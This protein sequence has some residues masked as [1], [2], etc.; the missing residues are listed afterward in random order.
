MTLFFKITDCGH[1]CLGFCGDPCPNVCSV[2]DP[3]NIIPN[4]KYILLPNCSHVLKFK[5]ITAIMNDKFIGL[6]KCPKCETMIN[7]LPRFKESLKLKK[8]QVVQVFDQYFLW[9]SNLSKMKEILINES[10][11]NENFKKYV[12]SRCQDKSSPLGLAE[13]QQLK[14]KMSL[15]RQ[16][17]GKTQYENILQYLQKPKTIIGPGYVQDLIKICPDLSLEEDFYAFSTNSWI[18][19]TDT[20]KVKSIGK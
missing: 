10:C 14:L 9:K 17:H 4:E 19:C 7:F 8:S 15:M 1:A 2:C 11:D 16:F 5:E 18:F 6:P 13:A 12:I 3:E 20:K